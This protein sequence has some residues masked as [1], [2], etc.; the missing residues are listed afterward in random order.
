MDRLGTLFFS[1]NRRHVNMAIVPCLVLG[2][3]RIPLPVGTKTLN[4]NLLNNHRIFSLESFAHG[5]YITIL[6]DIGTTGEYHISRRFAHPGRSVNISAMN[7]RRLLLDHLFAEDVF[8]DDT[9]RTGEV[10]NQL[11]SL[12]RQLRRRRQR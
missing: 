7:T 8:A 9:I 2:E 3:V 4:I 10:E 6:C 11:R 1:V 5:Q 12:Y